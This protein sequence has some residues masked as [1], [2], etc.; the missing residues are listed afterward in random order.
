[1]PILGY[2]LARLD[3]LGMARGGKVTL[4]RVG[5]SFNV[6]LSKT[7]LCVGFN[8]CHTCAVKLWKIHRLLVSEAL[9]LMRATF[10]VPYT[11]NSPI[12]GADKLGSDFL[13]VWLSESGEGGGAG[14]KPGGGEQNFES[15]QL[16]I[17]V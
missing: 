1:M 9:P 12:L 5:R 6:P 2:F 11:N 4:L 10:S 3:L 15:C 16:L 17:E 7:E 14:Q 13:K 8:D